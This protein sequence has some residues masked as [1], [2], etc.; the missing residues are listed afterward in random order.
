MTRRLLNLCCLEILP[1]SCW[2]QHCLHTGWLCSNRLKTASKLS[3]MTE[4]VTDCRLHL[5]MISVAKSS[6]QHSYVTSQ[7]KLLQI[8]RQL[9]LFST[10][11]QLKQGSTLQK[12]SRFITS[13]ILCKDTTMY[14]VFIVLLKTDDIHAIKTKWKTPR[15]NFSIVSCYLTNKNEFQRPNVSRKPSHE[16]KGM[17]TIKQIKWIIKILDAFV[18]NT[19]TVCFAKAIQH[20]SDP[21]VL[22]SISLLFPVNNLIT[23]LFP[24]FMT[25]LNYF[26]FSSLS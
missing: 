23:W 11:F 5:Y 21:W 25:R 20:S 16:T 10:D 7:T 18:R 1:S 24:W 3:D 15:L 13:L 17:P 2:I 22:T 14:N 26:C 12:V 4:S 9:R 6:T 19:F 8:L